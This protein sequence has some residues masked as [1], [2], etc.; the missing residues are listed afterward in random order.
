[1]TQGVLRNLVDLSHDLS[2]IK[3]LQRG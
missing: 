1:M 3:D 2:K